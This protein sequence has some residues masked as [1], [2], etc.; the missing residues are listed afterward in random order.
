M[1]LPT[2]THTQLVD[3]LR[4]ARVVLLDF[5]GPVAHLFAGHPAPDVAA[6]VRQFAT[7][8]GI[9]LT[10]VRT[11]D[12][13]VLL[14]VAYRHSPESGRDVE[15]HVIEHETRAAAVAE[16]APG[17][18]ELIRTVVATGRTVLVV[19]NNSE[20][21]IRTYL[22]RH[23][24]TEHVAHII[25]RP[26]GHP[27]QMKPDPHLLHAALDIARAAPADAV[28]VGDSITD[29]LAGVAAGVPC[30]GYA[31]RPE[32]AEGL[33]DADALLVVDD[34]HTIATALRP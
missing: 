24:L 15:A 19:S 34:M 23:D 26:F 7:V 9:D 8:R 28:F 11:D 3:L 14:R 5:D 2:G 4:G 13:L 27:E 12:P 32:R 29:A 31:K 6:A 16:P 17:A 30:I 10:E 22:A 33:T 18:H 20:R 25:G 21:A 1:T